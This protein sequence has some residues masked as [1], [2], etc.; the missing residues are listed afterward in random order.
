M[1]FKTHRDAIAAGRIRSQQTGCFAMVAFDSAT[2][3][4]EVQTLAER[5][6]TEAQAIAAMNA[7]RGAPST[8]GEFELVR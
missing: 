6:K 8:L 5:I 1:L 7:R 4:W 2:D 3:R